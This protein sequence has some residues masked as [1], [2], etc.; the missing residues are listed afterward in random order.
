MFRCCTS[1]DDSPLHAEKKRGRRH[2]ADHA[3][4]QIALI[5]AFRG[6]I[7]LAFDWLNEAYD[8]R[9]P[10]LTA[11]LISPFLV[12]LRDDPRWIPLLDKVGLPH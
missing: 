4:Y 9:D 10:G 11:L 7:D 6:E 5:Y 12:N 8:D 2:N 1:P 3:A